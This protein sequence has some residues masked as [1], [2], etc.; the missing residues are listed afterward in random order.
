MYQQIQKELIH[1]GFFETNGILT[2]FVGTRLYQV[3]EDQ[4]EIR[5]ETSFRGDTKAK[6]QLLDYIQELAPRYS[7]TQAKIRNQKLRVD[8]T[9]PGNNAL[10][11]ATRIDF[12]TQSLESGIARFETIEPSSTSASV[13]KAS[14]D[15]FDDHLSN[16]DKNYADDFGHYHSALDQEM[17]YYEIKNDFT[18]DFEADERVSL[19]QEPFSSHPSHHKYVPPEE[20][21]NHDAPL[22]GVVT[23][24]ID[25]SFSL[26]G[27]FGAVLGATLGAILMSGIHVLGAPVQ[28][29]AF[30]IPFL[31]IGIYRVMAGNQ[32]SIGLAIVLVLGSLFMGSVLISAIELLQQTDMGLRSAL[33]EGLATHYNN[34]KYFVTSVWI[35]L[36]LSAVAASI[37]TMLL[38][39]GGKRKIQY[40]K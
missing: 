25:R 3:I 2:K 19:R 18:E 34:E 21:P 31:I 23:G 36:G 32:M 7:L 38:L 30:L 8:L 16:H 4:G 33:L 15:H 37:P 1:K 5:I 6:N 39:T 27:F 13:A 22:D 24:L 35:R 40:S 10:L 9:E 29:V 26:L 11:E 14:P 12:L 20:N 17:D 28:L